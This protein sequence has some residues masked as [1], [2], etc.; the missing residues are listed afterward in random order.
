MVFAYE[1]FASESG[2]IAGIIQCLAKGHGF[3]NVRM[4]DFLLDSHSK[5]IFASR[6]AS[7]DVGTH[8]QLVQLL[9]RKQHRLR[10]RGLKKVEA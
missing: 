7:R 5:V 4:D 8:R 6:Y 10:E 9:E 2:D 3:S 1:H